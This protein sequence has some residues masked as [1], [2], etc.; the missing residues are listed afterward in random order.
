RYLHCQTAAQARAARRRARDHDCPRHRLRT[1]MR[2]IRT[3]LLVI[4]LVAL[5]TA[6]A[7]STFGFNVLFARTTSRSADSLL[8]ARASSELGLLTVRHGRPTASETS[9]DSLA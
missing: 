3:R 2:N 8:R 4:V 6:L 5:S 1:G 7:A 9:D